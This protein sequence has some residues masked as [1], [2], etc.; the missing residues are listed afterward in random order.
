MEIKGSSGSV[1]TS[2]LM[3]PLIFV[4]YNASFHVNG[5]N[6]VY[7][8]YP[9]VV[10]AN[11]GDFRVGRDPERPGPRMLMVHPKL[12]HS[13]LSEAQVSDDSG[14]EGFSTGGGRNSALY[15]FI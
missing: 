1:F 3:F 5:R 12:W 8:S 4:C 9:S 6:D 11:D 13:A 7:I 10:S 14:E 15:G 2:T